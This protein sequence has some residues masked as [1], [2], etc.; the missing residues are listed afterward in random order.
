MKSPLCSS[1]L[2]NPPEVNQY[3]DSY[4]HP[5]AFLRKFSNETK[6][7][8]DEHLTVNC[9]SVNLPTVFR[10]YKCQTFGAKILMQIFKPFLSKVPPHFVHHALGSFFLQNGSGAKQKEEREGSRH[11]HQGRSL[12]LSSTNPLVSSFVLRIARPQGARARARALPRSC[13]QT[14]Q[15]ARAEV[16]SCCA[17]VGAASLVVGGRNG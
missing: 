15:R 8:S 6:E 17:E 16:R 12:F 10:K 7:N 4:K 11:A 14:D 2:S 3:S 9:F 1:S 5:L 13:A